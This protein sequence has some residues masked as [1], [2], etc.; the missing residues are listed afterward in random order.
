MQE[1]KSSRS[2]TATGSEV[3]TLKARLGA[4]TFVLHGVSSL[5]E[6]YRK[7]LLR[8]LR[9]NYFTM[10]RKIDFRILHTQG[11]IRLH[12]AL[13]DAYQSEMLWSSGSISLPII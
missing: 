7:S 3:F 11:L 13:L 12:A 8:N 4:I 9:E 5:I 10:K 6:S 2:T 1:V